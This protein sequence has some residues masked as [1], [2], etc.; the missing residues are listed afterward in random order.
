MIS[1]DIL[2]GGTPMTMENPI[3]LISFE[4]SNIWTELMRGIGCVQHDHGDDRYQ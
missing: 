1:S 3:E 4:L 2:L